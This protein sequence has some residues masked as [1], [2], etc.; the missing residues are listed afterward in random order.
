[1]RTSLAVGVGGYVLARIGSLVFAE[2]EPLRRPLGLDD[3]LGAALFALAVLVPAWIFR[4]KL[5]TLPFV[6]TFPASVLALFLFAMCLTGGLLTA[7]LLGFG[8]IEELQDLHGFL[9]HTLMPL[10]LLLVG[11]VAVLG[12]IAQTFYVSLPL[13]W[14]G[15]WVVWRASRGFEGC[16]RPAL[17]AARS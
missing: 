1:M 5:A 15:T 14:L 3:L 17:D 6:A 13:A 8:R 4:R 2:F 10:L 11:T 12:A 9:E 7:C 16:E